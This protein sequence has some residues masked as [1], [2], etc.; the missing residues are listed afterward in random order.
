MWSRLKA[1][2]MFPKIVIAC[3][4]VLAIYGATNQ[5]PPQPNH[6]S[7]PHGTPTNYGGN[8]DAVPRGQTSENNLKAQLLAKFEAQYA[9]LVPKIKKC[10]EEQNQATAQMAAGAMNGEMMMNDP[11]CTQYLQQWVVDASFAETQIYRLK[12]GDT[13]STYMEINGAANHPGGSSASHRPSPSGD[14]ALHSVD[15]WDVQANTGKLAVHR[16]E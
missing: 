1:L 11:P 3:L 10:M 5:R 6:S 15:D 13:H 12:T 2:P 7:Q 16:R 4:V 8:P 9:E 14:D